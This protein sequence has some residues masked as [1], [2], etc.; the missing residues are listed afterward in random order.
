MTSNILDLQE[1]LIDVVIHCAD[2]LPILFELVN[3]IGSGEICFVMFCSEC[4]KKIIL[5]NVGKF[6]KC[7]YL[8][9]LHGFFYIKCIDDADCKVRLICTG[10]TKLHVHDVVNLFSSAI[11]ADGL[12]FYSVQAGGMVCIQRNAYT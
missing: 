2:Q 8:K 9:Y 10:N 1:K 11:K 6:W 12:A 3:V 5:E 7:L 4:L